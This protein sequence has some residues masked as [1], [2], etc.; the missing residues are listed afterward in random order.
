MARVA[1]FGTMQTNWR[2]GL[3]VHLRANGHEPVDNADARWPDAKTAEEINPLLAQDHGFMKSAD[4]AF[5]HHDADT[6]GDTARIELGMLAILGRPTVVHVDHGVTSR[7]YMRAL[8]IHFPTLHWAETAED[9][10]ALIQR[11]SEALSSKE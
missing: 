10:R 5:W 9:V 2:Y 8:C 4:I 11:L 7:E 6:A 3:A 1:L